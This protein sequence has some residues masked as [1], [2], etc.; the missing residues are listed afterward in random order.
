MTA[1]SGTGPAPGGQRPPRRF[2]WFRRLSLRTRLAL[3]F[4]VLIVSSASATI[5]IGNA[6]FG[7]KAAELARARLELD[8]KVAEQILMARLQ[9]LKFLAPAM[10]S[11]VSGDAID[12]QFCRYLVEQTPFGFAAVV[13]PESVAVTRF[14][15]QSCNADR[16]SGEARHRFA[17]SPLAEMAEA[18][19]SRRE[20]VSGLVVVRREDVKA[21]GYETPPENALMVAAASPLKAGGVVILGLMLNGRTELVQSTLDLLALQAGVAYKASIFLGTTRIA[22]TLNQEA[23]ATDVDPEVGRTVLDEART[24]VGVADVRGRRLNAAYKPLRDVHEDIVGMLGIATD[25]DLFGEI[26][27]RT[28]TLFST[29]IAVG[30]V[31]GLVMSYLFA[32]RL[33]RPVRELAEGM[34][35]VAQGDLNYKVRIQSGDE[36]GS[37]AGAFNRMV[38]EAKERDLRLREM[39]N[40]KLSQV[41]KQVSVGRLAAGVA[42][43]INNPLTAVLSLSML[44]RKN[45]P[46]GDPRMEDLDIIV[47]ETTRCRDIVRSLLDFARERPMEKR[48]VDVNQVVRDT[49]ALTAKYEALSSLSV[50]V[51]LHDAPL[52][53]NADP[54]QIMQVF[55]NLILNAAE[56]TRPGGTIRVTSDEDSS[57][58]FCVVA[59]R[60]TGKGIPKDC[61]NRVFE[62]FF[63]TKGTGKGTGLGLSVSL[64]IVQ[65]H[66]GA[67]EIESD[68]GR[69]TTV[70]VILPREG[71][72][73]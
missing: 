17:S 6:V 2:E 21:L 49:L 63:T 32:A 51:A 16:L 71:G 56:A 72:A 62:P 60:D 45:L 24:F 42:H 5:F 13:G 20:A 12:P 31:F 43:E 40:E 70:S 69:G 38:K 1:G 55:A 58:G 50:N 59:V 53:V 54:K 37:L 33:V 25:E 30:M 28:A 44:M 65:R 73:S 64:G 18:A 9:R 46:P 67:I 68:E 4:G 66:G 11:V 7:G 10:T 22:T 34:N 61:L 29:L 8:L 14:E 47:T 41:E 57:G 27:G 35:R 52:F 3:A 39:T 26:S 48:S 36:L 19:R 23:L 15:H